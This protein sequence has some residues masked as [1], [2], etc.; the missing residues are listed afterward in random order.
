MSHTIEERK[1]RD[2]MVRLIRAIDYIEKHQ[3]KVPINLPEPSIDPE[4]YF[5]DIP[6]GFYDEDLAEI[7][8][9]SLETVEA[10][11]DE[12][13]F[14][15]E[16]I[17]TNLNVA[18]N[19]NVIPLPVGNRGFL[20]AATIKVNDLMLAGIFKDALAKSYMLTKKDTGKD[21]GSAN[22][23]ESVEIC[24][25]KVGDPLGAANDDAKVSHENNHIRKATILLVAFLFT[26][27][28]FAAVKPAKVII[29]HIDKLLIESSVWNTPNLATPQPAR[30]TPFL[31]T[32]SL[33]E[34]NLSFDQ[35]EL[36]YNEADQLLNKIKRGEIHLTTLEKR[37]LYSKMY[38]LAK[39]DAEVFKVE[40]DTYD[41]RRACT[42]SKLYRYVVR[43][44]DTISSIIGD[45]NF[46][47][48]FDL[49]KIDE[50]LNIDDIVLVKLTDD[51]EV[52]RIDI[53][54]HKKSGIKNLIN[55]ATN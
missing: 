50:V 23:A 43:E 41:T 12:A 35:L 5:A 10:E 36:N 11:L 24:D 34:S 14:D 15:R 20:E 4:G 49:S 3:D 7:Q 9:M 27:M 17:T 13:G 26:S 42:E 48:K 45:C 28:C 8:A 54:K 30:A 44:K 25:N 52:I 29:A 16:T 18:A 31:T 40:D 32:S 55:S 51:F 47:V 39:E 2:L 22:A 38:S 46:T 6:D 19:N 21:T 1:S 37:A 53:D 33:I